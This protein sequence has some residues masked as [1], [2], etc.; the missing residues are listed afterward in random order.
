LLPE[1]AQQNFPRI[2]KKAF[3]NFEEENLSSLKFIGAM[4]SINS[5]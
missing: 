1:K 2:N 3:K 4:F 5:P